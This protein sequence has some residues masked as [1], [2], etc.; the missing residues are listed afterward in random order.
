MLAHPLQQVRLGDDRLQLGIVG[1]RR[2]GERTRPHEHRKEPNALLRAGTDD[3][4]GHKRARLGCGVARLAGDRE[5]LLG[6]AV[7]PGLA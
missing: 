6:H 1:P 3:S 7:G 2:L 4:G 5:T